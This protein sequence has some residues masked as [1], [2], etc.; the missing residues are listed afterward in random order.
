MFGS[1]H[2]LFPTL[3]TSGHL[4]R[5]KA[6]L[7]GFVTTNR[8][9][10]F[11]EGF[12]FTACPH[13]GGC[14]TCLSGW[15]SV[16]PRSGDL[17]LTVRRV[18]AD[19]WTKALRVIVP[20]GQAAPPAATH[21]FS[22]GPLDGVP[23][24]ERRTSFTP[25]CTHGHLTIPP[26]ISADTYLAL[27]AEQRPAWLN[28]FLGTMTIPPIS[29]TSTNPLLDVVMV[30]TAQGEKNCT[31]VF[32]LDRVLAAAEHAAAAA[33]KHKLGY[34]ETEAATPCLWWVKDEGTYLK[35][36][37]QD[38][39]DTRDADGRL[40]TVVHADGWGPG[41]D[42]STALGSEDLHETST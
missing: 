29:E 13:P 42:P 6:A 32:P 8:D 14:G 30:N 21:P 18:P 27:P 26:A 22:L 5:L 7:G 15:I 25:G 12:Y 23:G 2:D 28:T 4:D 34:A 37:G 11:Y 39:T 31:L 35:S 9:S 40:P 38:P 36:N 33:D 3:R 16:Y 19:Q 10:P 17:R 24:W 1:T 20:A 41:T